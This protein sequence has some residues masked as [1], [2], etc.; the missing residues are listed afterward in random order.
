[1]VD[2]VKIRKKAK[3]G[4]EEKEEQPAPA[5]PAPDIPPDNQPSTVNR[6]LPT[7]LD[8]FK[9]TAGQ[10]RETV[11]VQESAAEGAQHELLHFIIA[12][13]QYA[14]DIELEDRN[15]SGKESSRPA[16]TRHNVECSW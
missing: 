8:Q 2:L 12:A 11:K 3:K 16:D 7:K 1:M 13:E 10:K 4:K 6:Q 9:A 5:L 15:R 14:L